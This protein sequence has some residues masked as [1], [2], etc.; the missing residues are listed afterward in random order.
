MGEA[1][2][3]GGRGAGSPRPLSHPQPHLG[4]RLLAGWM[5]ARDHEPPAGR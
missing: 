3:C 4:G 5:L 1:D 2:E